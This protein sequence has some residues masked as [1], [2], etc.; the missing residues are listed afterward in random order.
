MKYEENI[1]RLIQIVQHWKQV[2]DSKEEEYFKYASEYNNLL[3]N[4]SIEAE[5]RR[6]QILEMGP[7]DTDYDELD[8]A[9]RNLY[10]QI[11]KRDVW[12]IRKLYNI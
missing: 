6:R 8:L 9:Y 5:E 12:F 7:R 2:I 4:D 11:P 3:G 1:K 10:K